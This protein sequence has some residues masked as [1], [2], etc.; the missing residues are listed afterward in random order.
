MPKT[1]HVFLSDPSLLAW[2]TRRAKEQHRSKKGYIE[3]LIAR[4]RESVEAEAN[5]E[6]A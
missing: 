3:W 5:D 1:L 4:D 2:V 6:A